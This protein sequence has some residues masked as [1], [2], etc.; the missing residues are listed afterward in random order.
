MWFYICFIQL[1]E[2]F[3]YL[4]GKPREYRH[5]F[6]SLDKA[7]LKSHNIYILYVCLFVCLFV[8]SFSSHLRIFNSFGDVTIAGEGL[9][10]LTYMYARHFWSL[11]REDSLAFDIYC[12][13]GHP[14]IMVI[15]GYPWRSH[16]LP[17]VWQWNFHYLFYRL[18]S[19]VARTRKNKLPVAGRTLLPIAPPPRPLC[20]C[21]ESIENKMHIVNIICWL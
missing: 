14:F 15:S 9:Q 21:S 1:V 11:S 7:I 4:L 3:L 20:F 16:L 18:K 8:W 10:I 19:V 12:D 6:T 13:T 5:P 17:S 2:W